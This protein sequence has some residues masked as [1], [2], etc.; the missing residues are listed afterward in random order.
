MPVLVDDITKIITVREKIK[1]QLNLKQHRAASPT[2][3]K[4]CVTFNAPKT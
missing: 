3:S 2:R 1:L 4:I